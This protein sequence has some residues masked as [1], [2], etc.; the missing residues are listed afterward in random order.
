MNIAQLEK[1]IQNYHKGKGILF[2]MSVLTMDKTL[3]RDLYRELAFL[4][5]EK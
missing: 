1:E 3:I 4:R 2:Y 5:F